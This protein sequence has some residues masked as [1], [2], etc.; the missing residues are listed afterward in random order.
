MTGSMDTNKPDTEA[1]GTETLDTKTIRAMLSLQKPTVSYTPDIKA[2]DPSLQKSKQG[3]LQE[4]PEVDTP[5]HWQGFNAD[6][7]NILNKSDYGHI[8]DL[9]TQKASMELA[10]LRTSIEDSTWKE[11]L[12]TAADVEQLLKWNH[13]VLKRTLDLSVTQ[14]GRHPSACVCS[15]MHN[16]ETSITGY[17]RLTPLGIDHTVTLEGNSTQDVLV[18]GL[19]RPSTLF[20][21]NLLLPRPR[22]LFRSKQS[23][24]VENES[25]YLLR[26]LAHHCSS[27]ETR[28]GYIMTE[29]ALTACRFSDK[30][31]A[32]GEAELEGQKL[33]DMMV[34]IARIP[35]SIADEKELTTDL[36]LWWLCMMQLSEIEKKGPTRV[37]SQGTRET[38]QGTRETEQL[39]H[40]PDQ[41]VAPMPVVLSPQADAM[42]NQHENEA[43]GTQLD[44]GE[45]DQ[46]FSFEQEHAIMMDCDPSNNSNA[47]ITPAWDP[48]FPI[49][50][51]FIDTPSNVF[52]PPPV[53]MDTDMDQ[54][55]WE[56]ERSEGQARLDIE[57]QI[58]EE[59]STSLDNT[60]L[61][62]LY[63][64]AF[65]PFSTLDSP[66]TIH[67]PGDQHAH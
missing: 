21:A 64:S 45:G 17:S 24:Q 19:V 41:C 49:Q 39:P 25:L 28:Y 61:G 29:K 43:P 15:H 9:K 44:I 34:E 65:S 42:E 16:D 4:W 35:W 51:D 57:A 26:Q 36:A 5:G 48:L 58:P 59:T 33:K 53:M 8:L 10:A 20:D 40:I 56:Y 63:S 50:Q 55:N 12:T 67:S 54:R 22:K 37:G 3:I 14:L 27:N 47:V 1:P 38:G 7:L 60:G 18:I 32:V 52:Y 6:T 66:M 2:R 13:K 62:T 46:S 11:N 23:R 30:A 31:C